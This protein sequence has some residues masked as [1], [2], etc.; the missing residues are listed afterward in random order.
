MTLVSDRG[1]FNAVSEIQAFFTGFYVRAKIVGCFFLNNTMKF[2]I[3]RLHRQTCLP[4][5]NTET[6]SPGL[7]ANAVLQP[8]QATENKNYCQS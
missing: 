3:F 5:V 2:C 1:N 4:N 6:S 7:D 8:R